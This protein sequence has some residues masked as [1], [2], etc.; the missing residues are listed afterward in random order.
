[1]KIDFNQEY[2]Q[3]GKKF[4]EKTSKSPPR[5]EVDYNLKD[6]ITEATLFGLIDKATNILSIGSGKEAFVIL[7]EKNDQPVVLKTF[8][9]YSA[10]NIKRTNA[11]HHISL[12]GMAS[13]IAKAE[14]SNLRIL[15][16]YGVNVPKPLEYKKGSLGF[17]MTY[18]M[19]SAT[20][21][22]A[23]LLKHI[24]LRKICDPKDFLDLVLDEIAKMFKQATMVHGDLSEFNILVN[25]GQPII[26]DVTQS[27]LY[28]IKTFMET[29]VRIR[30][31][32]AVEVLGRD[33]KNILQYFTKKYRV[34]YSY[35]DVMQ[36]LLSDVSEFMKKY[37]AQPPVP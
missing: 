10:S 13:I 30:I 3:L 11:Q 2:T 18:V 37:H 1:M 23:P 21:K 8:K 15:D 12:H 34:I 33:I 25:N 28:N 7:A 29:P 6:A 35:E 14:Y 5:K 16:Y 24:D 19:D 20:Y 27:R 32:D 9:P 17:T 22:S 36:S 4:R 31:D 26:I